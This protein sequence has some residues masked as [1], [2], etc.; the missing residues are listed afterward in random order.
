[1]D[2]YQRATAPPARTRARTLRTPCSRENASRVVYLDFDGHVT[3]CTEWNGSP[4]N[5]DWCKLPIETFPFDIDGNP[6][7]FNAEERRRIIAIWRAVAEDFAPFDVDVTTGGLAAALAAGCVGV[8]CG[9]AVWWCGA[10]VYA[11]VLQAAGW[12]VLRCGCAAPSGACCSGQT[13]RAQS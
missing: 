3:S 9:C 5:Q 6:D 11:C 7:A 12:M 10:D 1:M 8:R 2:A 4:S 13:D